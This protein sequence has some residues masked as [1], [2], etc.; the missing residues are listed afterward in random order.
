[1][2]ARVRKIIIILF[3]VLGA[4]LATL[5]V[6]AKVYDAEV[7]QKL[8]GAMNDRLLSPVSV[9][10]MDLTLIARFPMASLR[11]HD[12]KVDEVRTD[13]QRPDTLLAVK[14]LF[15]EFNLWELFG[16]DY[17]VQ[18]IHGKGVILYPGLDANGVENFK[19]WKSDTTG[20]AS[21]PIALE[22]VTVD[23][24][25]IRYRDDRDRTEVLATG[26]TLSVSGSFA[27]VMN[28]LHVAGDLHIL[29]IAVKG[30]PMIA[31]RR[32]RISLDMSFNA[33]R[34]RIEKGEVILG[35]LPLEVSLGMELGA[36]E[37]TLDLR[38]SG[39]D[40]DIAEL[41]AQLP[42]KV[43]APFARYG[44]QGR[45][46]LAVRYTGPVDSPALSIG[47]QVTKTRMKERVTGA[48]FTDINGE[49]GVDFAP[50][51]SL[52]MLKIKDLHARSGDGT[53][54]GNWLSAGG[55]KASMKS[56]IRCDVSLAELLRFAGVD[57]L[58]HV[59]GRLVAEIKAE[60]T[61]RD[62]SDVRAADLRQLRTSGTVALRDATL[63]MKG[64]RHRVEH[65]DAELAVTGND[66]HVRGLKATLQGSTV[67]LSGIL[68]NLIPFLLLD[69]ERLLIEAKGNSERLDLASLLQRTDGS[70]Q[71]E[72][73]DDY[74]LV[75]PANIDLDL[76]ARIG[77]LVFE[78]FKATDITGTIGLKNRVLRV[79]PVSFNTADGAVLG[80]LDLDGRGGATASA[81]PLAI[82]ATVKGIDLKALF[83]EFQD[84]GQG[85]LTH[86]QLSG[87]AQASVVFRAPL[88]SSMTL[89]R[90]K[91][92]CTVDIAVDK[93]GI[94]G[95]Q[96]L[97]AV[98][99]HL[100]KNK[101][102]SP[103]VNTDEL[104]KR[105]ADV[106]FERLE[107]RIE[108]RD[109]GVYI[110]MM[111]V[112][113]NAMDIALS[114]TQWFDDRIDHHLIFRLSDLFRMGKQTDDQFGPVAD[115]GTGMRV[116]LH[117][118]GDASAPQFEN[119]GAMAANRRK[120][121]FQ[122]EKQELRAILRED[123]LGKRKDEPTTPATTGTGGRIIIE[124]DSASTVQAKPRSR[125]GRLLR[126][127]KPT[128]QR[129]EILIEE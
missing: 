74:I 19:I 52:R 124:Q 87:R 25:L 86:D 83:S 125:T 30:E 18:R 120:Q 56:N 88:R 78:D 2:F 117:M 51:G 110:P 104:R 106:R 43:C 93:G 112:R 122:Q 38:A 46:D 113:S 119:D 37:Q 31:D 10:D 12:V 100:Q 11:L 8:V 57:T 71:S 55:R 39:L 108:I 129:G 47:A 126:E 20:A 27:D 115:D 15:L 9:S 35:D 49:V 3:S 68:H 123:I 81:Y 33:D 6:L 63:K 29:S 96:Q 105:L 45:V 127:D 69:K 54:S 21:S 14:E 91:I 59:G 99:D 75:L 103:F 65:L 72:A 32:T 95:N 26:R 50:D 28:E 101:L 60:G 7:K 80:S 44:M 94:K 90:E 97:L 58:E 5:L 89:D 85:F 128:P 34:F 17:H 64:V 77:E 107:N 109:G 13:D 92:L 24:A 22:A 1:M 121:Q 82:E 116:F 67:Q 23:G 73:P 40:L 98:A 16:G 76:K 53:I 48:M 84:F 41:F 111:E 70:V 62:M 4:G 42:E 118:Y 79:S 61:M 114:G 102:V 66:A 36:K